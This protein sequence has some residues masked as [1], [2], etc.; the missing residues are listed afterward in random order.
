MRIAGQLIAVVVLTSGVVTAESPSGAA[1]FANRGVGLGL[2]VA[3]VFGQD[4][5][6]P[7]A[8]SPLW[9][10]YAS[11]L[12][13]GFE[14]FGRVPVAVASVR[15]GAEAPDGRGLVFSSGLQLGVRYLFLEEGVRPF[16]SLHLGG[17]IVARQAALGDNVLAGPGAGAGLEVFVVSSVALQARVFAEWYVTLNAPQRFSLGAT[18]TASTYF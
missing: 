4:P 3:R 9:L 17:L 18:V 8:V 6:V 11:Y 14:V 7:D 13:G 1:S 2:G 15:V 10:E 12:E 16:V 5:S